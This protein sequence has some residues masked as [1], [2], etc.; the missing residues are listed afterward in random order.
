MLVLVTGSTGYAGSRLVPM[1]LD[2]GHDVRA[3]VIDEEERVP[4]WSDRVE[5]VVMDALDADAV[6][7]AVAGVDAVYYLIHGMGGDDFMARDHEAAE[8]MVAAVDRHRVPRVIYLSGIVPDVPDDELSEHI[9]SRKDVEETLATSGA[10]TITLRAA[11]LLG[12]GSTS[13]EVVRQVSERMPVQTVPRWMDSTVQPIAAVDALTALV[14]ALTVD[15]P[16]RHYDVGGPTSLTY[17]DLLD[18]YATVAGLKRIQVGVPLVPERLVALLAGR[19]VDVPSGVVE[20]LIESLQHDMV[21]ADEDFH[22]LLP[23]GHRLT[24]IEEAVQRSLVDPPE[25][26]EG[27]DPMAP[28]PQDPP[29]A[30]GG[31]GDSVGTTVAGLVSRVLPDR[32]QP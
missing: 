8:H 1:L 15:S 30:G 13:F 32:R 17:A 3:A 20:S 26:P 14:G 22:A 6:E 31:Q 10:V 25:D 11:I 16:T 23:A 7:R 19:I 12:S 5:T 4:W 2:Q 18:R 24:G 27:A 21:C 29:W 28:L 9:A